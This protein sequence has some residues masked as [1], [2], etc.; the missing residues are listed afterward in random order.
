MRRQQHHKDQKYVEDSPS[1]ENVIERYA[2][3]VQGNAI[4]IGQV[5]VECK[6][7][8]GARNENYDQSWKFV[9]RVSARRSLG[10][11]RR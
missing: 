3:F 7:E 4:Q 10:D 1:P 11:L 8:P 9:S 2:R 6:R 5:V